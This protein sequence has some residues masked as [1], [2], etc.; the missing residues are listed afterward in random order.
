MK[1]F[2]LIIFSVFAA[3]TARAEEHD[4]A[5]VFDKL[6]YEATVHADN[7]WSVH[8]TIE[9][10]FSEKRHGIFQY[11]ELPFTAK[12]EGKVYNYTTD[13]SDVSVAGEKFKVSSEENGRYRVIRIG[14]ADRTVFGSH[15]YNIDYTLHFFD[16]GYAGADMLYASVL[17]AQ[18]K[19]DIR[20][21]S[22]TIQFDNPLPAGFADSLKV[23]SG[24][25]ASTSNG[26][27]V[28]W[29]VDT[30]N[31]RIV[32]QASGISH[33]NAITL[34]AALP[35]GY[36][37]MTG[38]GPAPK[39][40]SLFGGSQSGQTFSKI[41]NSATTVLSVLAFLAFLAA[42]VYLLTHRR[43]NPIVSVEYSVPDGLS[44]A[45]V[46][47]VVDN[48]ADVSDLSSLIVWWAS[49][50][51]LTIEEEQY[52]PSLLDRL[53]GHSPNE[54]VLTVK[55]S[56]PDDAPEFQQKF[57]R[58]FFGGTSQTCRLSDL[59]DKHEEI[60]SAKGS[61]EESFTDER[62]LMQTDKMAVR[63]MLL[64][65]VL[66]AVTFVISASSFK[67]GAYVAFMWLVGILVFGLILKNILE[68]G[69]KDYFNKTNKGRWVGFFSLLGGFAAS[70]FVPFAMM[71][72]T[73]LG[74]E[75]VLGFAVCGL[76]LAFFMYHTQKN[77]PYRMEMLSRILGFKEFIRAA[78]MPMLKAMVDENPSY[79]Y[80]V[81]PY[82]IAFGLSDKW[83]KQFENIS[84]EAPDWYVC[85][86][87]TDLNFASGFMIA[88]SL[89]D[90]FDSVIASS[91]QS[92]S[93]DPSSSDSGGDSGGGYSGGG[94]GGGGGGS[95]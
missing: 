83:C 42:L 9:A 80:D 50:G 7:S 72:D 53:T 61:L 88:Q 22:F 71:K 14:D 30:L 35:E 77:T 70:L 5:C 55:K 19:N 13:V 21:F 87:V 33:H 67:Y 24:T 18:W 76:V 40:S 60:Q 39:A 82:A 3:L 56:L 44:S 8:E 73:C 78:E 11:I 84:I 28:T 37:D 26:L 15:T 79:F 2:F 58:V 89:T 92:S 46:G 16:D 27:G 81:L 86:G 29:E 34:K 17:G 85:D 91:I 10:N 75:T 52:E 62:K 68:K 74:K 66:A 95:W 1:H 94:G 31:N 59:G 23:Y 25:L 38:V 47:Y 93:V 51:Y 32:G 69:F 64:F 45:E 4:D 57:W 43:R 63:L 20:E 12:H 48:T 6:E 65:Y 49:R 41:K 36:W 54:I 90:S